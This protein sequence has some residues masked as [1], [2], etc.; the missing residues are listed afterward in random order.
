[1][2]RT[3]QIIL[4]TLLSGLMMTAIANE[5]DTNAGSYDGTDS[6]PEAAEITAEST[7]ATA[8][9]SYQASDALLQ[10]RSDWE[11]QYSRLEAELLLEEDYAAQEVLERQLSRLQ[12]EFQRAELEQL[13][14]DAIADGN[15]DY[16]VKLQDVI[17]HGLS[18]INNP[19]PEVTVQR[20]RVTGKALSG[21]E[22]GVK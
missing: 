19:Y 16:A 15:D 7:T 18:P 21:E 17:D 6:V 11:A 3:L 12:M 4:T 10:L 5:R 20:D 22:G 13:L 9:Y 14:A 1:M 2:K 8:V